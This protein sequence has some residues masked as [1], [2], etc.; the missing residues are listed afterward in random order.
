M[1]WR[2]KRYKLCGDVFLLAGLAIS[3][4]CSTGFERSK[5]DHAVQ[6]YTSLSKQGK[7]TKAAILLSMHDSVSLEMKGPTR[8]SLTNSEREPLLEAKEEGNP[9]LKAKRLTSSSVSSLQAYLPPEHA[10]KSNLDEKWH[11]ELGWSLLIDGKYE[12]AVAAYR[13]ALR[14]NREVAEAYL[15]LG[16]SLR[17]QNQT[18]AAIEAY[19][20]AL[21]LNPDYAA[22][23]VHLG[24]IYA[25]GEP[26]YRDVEKAKHLFYKASQHGD[27][28]A[29]IALRELKTRQ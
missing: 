19:Q 25:D 28:F 6:T 18:P 9:A 21:K 27:P 5:S 8:I 1:N 29:M 16:I 24:Y 4:G 14:Q 23:L 20:H 2:T 26:E 17:M 12:G 13:E 15:G 11:T 22:A 10:Q 3:L 7:F